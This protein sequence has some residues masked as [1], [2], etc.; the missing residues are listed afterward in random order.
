MN[1]RDELFEMW[2]PA[3][4]AW[5][6][7]AKPVL[8][9][10]AA[11]AAAEPPAEIGIDLAIADGHTALVLDLPG[12]MGVRVAPGL[13]RAGYR[14]VPLY[15]GA[16]GAGE[17]VE[18]WPIVRA[19]EELGPVVREA[20]RGLPEDAPPAFLLDAR[21]RGPA[22]E[23]GAG[24]FDNRSISLP[25]DFPSASTLRG[26]GI[27]RVIL[28]QDE[29]GPPQV[30]LAHT[31]LRYQEAGIAIWARLVSAA[32]EARAITVARPRWYRSMFQR[33]LATLGL[34][35]HP[36]GGFGGVLGEGSGG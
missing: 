33:F 20:S 5:S 24:A 16:P 15:N 13:T 21:R 36:L 17:V 32:E 29:A 22:G 2:A 26:R 8:F 12:E 14:P 35:R 31:L 3:E 27:G 25:T 34:L 11:E 28:V 30:D 23:V 1:F 10:H 6:D 18:V 7:W 9:A 4:S 19:L